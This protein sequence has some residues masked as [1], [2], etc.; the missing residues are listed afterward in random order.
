MKTTACTCG[1][2]YGH[3][4][5]AAIRDPQHFSCEVC[6]VRDALLRF[7]FFGVALLAAVLVGLTIL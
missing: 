5:T 7:S 1:A 2:L 3:R 4:D 6:E